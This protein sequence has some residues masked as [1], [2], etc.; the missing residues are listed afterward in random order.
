MARSNH[1]RIR[2]RLSDKLG[3]HRLRYIYHSIFPSFASWVG[4]I[5]PPTF[6]SFPGLIMNGFQ[7]IWANNSH[8]SVFVVALIKFSQTRLI[9]LRPLQIIKIFMAGRSLPIKPRQLTSCP[10]LSLSSLHYNPSPA[11]SK[12]QLL[13]AFQTLLSSFCPDL[14]II[15]E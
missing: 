15:I 14:C 6:G 2:K 13:G 12:T 8:W 9:A 1:K 4:L 7:F 3:M 10:K 5:I 11:E